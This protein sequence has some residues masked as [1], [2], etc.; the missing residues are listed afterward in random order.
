MIVLLDTDVL[1][2]VALDRSPHLEAPT[3]LIDA[4][5]VRPAS[6]FVAWRSESE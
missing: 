2:D 4:L 6:A 5:E 3:A 1:I